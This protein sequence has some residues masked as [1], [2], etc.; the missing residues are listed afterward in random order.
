MKLFFLEVVMMIVLPR[1]SPVRHALA[2]QA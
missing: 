1:S 2:H